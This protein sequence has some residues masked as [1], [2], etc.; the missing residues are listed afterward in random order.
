MREVR[1]PVDRVLQAFPLSPPPVVQR[2][3]IAVLARDA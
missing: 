2:A 3:L 1:D